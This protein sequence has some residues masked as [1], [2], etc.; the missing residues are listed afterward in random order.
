MMWWNPN[1][2]LKIPYYP[3]IDEKDYP[4]SLGLKCDQYVESTSHRFVF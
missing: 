2:P 1:N 4:D 3:D